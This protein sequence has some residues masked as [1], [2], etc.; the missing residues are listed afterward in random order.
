MK[1]TPDKQLLNPLHKCHSIVT[2]SY[3]RHNCFELLWFNDDALNGGET[4]HRVDHQKLKIHNNSLQLV[5]KGQI[6]ELEY[7]PKGY[8]IQFPDHF[9]Q[10]GENSGFRILFNPFIN[11]PLIIPADERETIATIYGLIQKEMNG[12]NSQ[13]VIYGYLASLLYKVSSL[14][15]RYNIGDESIK[16]FEALYQLIEQNFRT[17]RKTLFYADKVGLTPKRLNEILKEKI[18]LTLT[19]LLHKILIGEAKRMIAKGDKNIKEVAFDLG[20]NEQAYFSRF[21]K[22]HVGVNPEKFAQQISED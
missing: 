19:Q 22:R 9:F 1:E 17:E 16:P 6:Y 13:M 14:W 7:P 4:Y 15:P 3:A 21:F 18:G 20:F 5:S 10:L 8:S 12:R 2:N 11:D